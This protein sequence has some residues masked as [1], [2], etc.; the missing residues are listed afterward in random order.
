MTIGVLEDNEGTQS[1]ENLPRGPRGEVFHN[2]PVVGSSI[3][4]IRNSEE[5]KT[6][7][8]SILSS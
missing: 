6:V 7:N 4:A 1:E 8:A 5:E 2:H 3:A